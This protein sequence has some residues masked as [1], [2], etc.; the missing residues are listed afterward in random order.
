MDL[1]VSMKEEVLQPE[2]STFV[3]VPNTFEMDLVL[4]DD[5]VTIANA[6]TYEGF[7]EVEQ[8]ALFASLRQ[9]GSDPLDPEKGIMWS[10]CLIGEISPDLLVTQIKDA[11]YNTAPG[12]SV[13]FFIEND[14][15]GMQTLSYR[16]KVIT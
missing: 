8:S 10:E 1:K 7:D 14:S 13:D 6:K 9:R 16:I 2:G 5:G 4:M 12:C 11:V 15:D 3:Y